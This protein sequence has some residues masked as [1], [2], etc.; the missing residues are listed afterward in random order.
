MAQQ[1]YFV[2]E[3]VSWP[4][5]L[6]LEWIKRC[7]PVPGFPRVIQIQTRPGC[8]SRC[9]FCP[10]GR[11]IGKIPNVAMPMALFQ[12]IVDECLDHAVERIS[13]YLM[14]EPLL[15]PE[16]GEKIA[17]VTRRR[18]QVGSK[19]VVKINSNGFLLDER[20]ARALLDSG[21]DRI[22]FS[23]HGIV[24]EVYEK[25]MVNLKLD[26]VLKN[27]DRFLELKKAGGYEK[28]RVRVTMVKTKYLEPQLPE[29]LRYW[30]E[31]DVKVNVRGLENRSNPNVHESMQQLNTRGWQSFAWCRRM[32]EQVYIVSTGELV[33][34]C[35]DWDR[36]AVMGRL[37]DGATI[38]EIWNGP[39]YREMRRRFLANRL[40]DTLCAGCRKEA[41]DDD[42]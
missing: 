33:L 42:Q 40:E 36:R 9:I 31:R 30:G 32:F 19:A 5:R 27:I 11:T 2:S 38:S 28:P 8:P 20:Q 26:R 24:P 6:Y 10:N 34:C 22:S 29:I 16:I 39:V 7:E 35:V 12:R 18:D 21:L 17:Y 3:L 1:K 14:C 4:K 13:P 15:D 37:G 25:T 41:I 23:V